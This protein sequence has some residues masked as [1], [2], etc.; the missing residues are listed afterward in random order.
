MPCSVLIVLIVSKRRKKVGQRSCGS[1]GTG[2]PL[3][4]GCAQPKIIAAFLDLETKRREWGT[5]SVQTL[6]AM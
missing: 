3:F 2:I 6:S 5:V 1:R 4:R